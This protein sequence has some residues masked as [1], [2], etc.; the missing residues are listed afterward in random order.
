MDLLELPQP[1]AEHYRQSYGSPPDRYLYVT[2]G[3]LK[4]RYV[5]PD[6]DGVRQLKKRYVD[7]LVNQI[8]DH[9]IAFRKLVIS[10]ETLTEVVISL[11]RSSTEAAAGECL[12]EVRTSDVFEISQTPRN[13][14]DAAAAHFEYLHGKDPN[15]GEFMDYQVMMEE[16]IRYVETWDTDFESF[17]RI[18]LLPLTRWGV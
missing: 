15:F 6:G 10:S 9:E 2:R 14:F 17:D 12:N 5:D 16:R 13:R 3:F 1:T 7:E 18:S 11:Q 8:E 4:A